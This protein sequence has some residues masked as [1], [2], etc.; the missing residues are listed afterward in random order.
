MKLSTILGTLGT[1]AAVLKG[2]ST[3][4]IIAGALY[5]VDCRMSDRRAEAVDRCWMTALPIMGLGAAARSSWEAGFQTFNP[6]LRDPSG[7][8]RRDDR[9]RFSA[10][11]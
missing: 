3:T 4:A 6:A 11:D 7:R 10:E 1:T 8:R 5:L 9:G 2:A